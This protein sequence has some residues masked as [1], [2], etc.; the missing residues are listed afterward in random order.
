MQVVELSNQ[1]FDVKLHIQVMPI[2]AKPPHTSLKVADE[3]FIATALLHREQPQR[4]DFTVSEI[5]ARAARENLYGTLRPGIQVHASLHLCANRPPNP[6]R[7]RMLFATGKS[8]R[9]LYRTGDPTH[10]LR[11]GK[12]WPE[13]KAIP[14]EYHALL[15]WVKKEFGKRSA[16]GNSHWLEGLRGMIGMGHGMWRGQDPDEYVSKLR[17]GWD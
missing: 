12:V 7:Y 11:T 5:V 13:R 3:T 15:D 4:E 2:T 9:R 17:E 10:P 1:V 14:P 8:T 16:A 6:G